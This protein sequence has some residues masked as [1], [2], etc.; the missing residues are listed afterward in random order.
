MPIEISGNQAIITSDGVRRYFYVPANVKSG[1]VEYNLIGGG[2][3]AGGSDS[4]YGGG[5]GGAAGIVTGTLNVNAGD[6]VELIVGGG[7]SRGESGRGGARGGAGGLSY[8]EYN[9]GAGGH[10]G[11]A[12]SSGGGGGGGGATVL[13][14][15]GV[16]KAVA[17][18]GGAGGGGGHWNNGYGDS[19][20]ITEGGFNQISEGN[21]YSPISNG[22][23]CQFLN[24]YGV[25][26]GYG[27][28]NVT[29]Q[30]DVYFPITRS[31]TFN[32]SGDNEADILIDAVQVATTGGWGGGPGPFQN[33][34]SGTTNVNQGWHSITI[35]GRNYGGPGSVG[36]TITSAQTNLSGSTATDP[37]HNVIAA[38][39]SGYYIRNSGISGESNFITGYAVVVNGNIIYQSNTGVPP[40]DSIRKT[41]FVGYSYFTGGY[42]YEYIECFNFELVGDEIW[43]SRNVRKVHISTNG[44]QGT[45]HPGDGGGGGGGGGGYLGGGGGF[46]GQTRGGDLGGGAGYIGRSY[47]EGGSITPQITNKNPTYFGPQGVGGDASYPGFGGT[48]GNGGSA[49]IFTNLITRNLRHKVNGTWMSTNNAY[50]KVSGTW[51]LCPEVWIKDNGTWKRSLL[52][53]VAGVTWFSDTL[54]VIPSVS[55]PYVP[56]PVTPTTP[57]TVS[58][59]PTHPARG[60][61]KDILCD[62]PKVDGSATVYYHDGV[63]GEYGEP[64]KRLTACPIDSGTTACLEKGK[65]IRESTQVDQLGEFSRTIVYHWYA[66]GL[67]GEYAETQSETVD[68]GTAACIAKGTFIRESTEV[69][70]RSIEFERTTVYYWYADGL[71]GEYAEMQSTTVNRRSTPV[72]T[73]T[74]TAATT[75]TT[76]VITIP[77]VTT[78]TTTTTDTGGFDTVGTDTVSDS[79]SAATG[80]G[81]PGESASSTDST[82]AATGIGNPGESAAADAADA[83]AAAVGDA[84]GSPDGGGNSGGGGGGG[85]KIICTKLFELGL[86]SEEIYLADQAFGA[87][88]VQRSPDIYNGY[89]AW[90]EIVVDWM[91]GRGPKMMPWMSDEDFSNAAKKWSTTW[92]VDIATPW[93]EQMAYSMGKKS[94]GSLT[95]RMITAAGIPICKVVGVW[96]RV[97]GPSKKPAGFGKG[98]MLIPVFIMFKLV[99]ELGRLIE[100]K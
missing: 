46:S 41:D 86:M 65:F 56:D 10:A 84:D 22:A 62:D 61:L 17:A 33:V 85:G 58:T 52:K 100:R 13:K 6:L 72:V 70:S 2:G 25:D 74:T 21:Y 95:G 76:T 82:S 7:G 23:Y 16:V 40:S 53:T 45:N 47:A 24:N 98:L 60:V 83:A 94:S 69:D 9:G 75:T 57:I 59:L 28:T 19:A 29:Y 64:E 8:A 39:N 42:E 37:F 71:C 67:C 36:G 50:V 14:I 11:Y 1:T 97:F 80:I 96:Q 73:T 87:E 51:K 79:T 99:A 49:F 81:N 12:G 34:F 4:P 38:G 91:D 89:R 66:D 92:A 27:N 88:L 32:V 20:T 3:G 44:Q 93:A 77:T 54:G 26:I 63:G 68:R 18:G 48:D 90:A 5:S 55:D 31:Y 78:T 30:W 35:N 15:N 43:N